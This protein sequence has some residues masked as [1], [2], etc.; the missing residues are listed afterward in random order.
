MNHIAIKSLALAATITG[1]S[2]AQST[3]Q[4]DFTADDGRT[5]TKTDSRI[6]IRTSDGDNEEEIVFGGE[7][8]DSKQLWKQIKDHIDEHQLDEKTLEAVQKALEHAGKTIKGHFKSSAIILDD[9]GKRHHVELHNSAFPDW[10]SSS[11]KTQA[12]FDS[13]WPHVAKALKRLE[14]S[15]ETIDRARALSESYANPNRRHMIGVQCHKLDPLL[16]SQLLLDHGIVVDQVFPDTPAEKAGV[17]KHDILLK[18]NGESL[19]DVKDLID[20]IQAAGIEDEEVTLTLI[21]GGEEQ[22]RSMKTQPQ[23]QHEPYRTAID[24]L[25]HQK[26]FPNFKQENSFHQWQPDFHLHS[27]PRFPHAQDQEIEALEE[28]VE[29]LQRTIEDLK[30]EIEKA[31][32]KK[33][34]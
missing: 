15:E 11:N 13:L 34:E 29:D 33:K 23:Q 32:E 6:V 22:E 9:Q 21:R 19:E 30:G 12:H 4:A 25:Q 24:L 18:A 2:F 8:V 31:T 20:A 1:T 26:K 7:G 10:I 3:L 16:S 5:K 27:P 14:V 17:E 28:T